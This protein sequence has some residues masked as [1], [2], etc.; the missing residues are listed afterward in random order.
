VRLV[1]EDGLPYRASSWHL[2][3]DHRVFVPY[4]TIQNWAEAAG[5]KSGTRI[6]AGR[7]WHSAA[8]S[9]RGR[10]PAL[11]EHRHLFVRRHLTAAERATVQ[12]LARGGGP[13]RALRAIMDEVYRLF[14]RRCP[15]DT[16]GPSWPAC[17]S[18]SG[19]TA[20]WGGAR[21]SSGRRTWRK[22]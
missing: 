14:D 5:E 7:R 18:G 17:A 15:T 10:A 2:W 12:R 4:A 3:R 9:L 13:L 11:F 16:G 21:T 19:V 8:R 1:V 20:A 22:P 6:E